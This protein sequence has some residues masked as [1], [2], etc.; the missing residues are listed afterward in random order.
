MNGPR[1]TAVFL[2]VTGVLFAALLVA[3]GWRAGV[4]GADWMAPAALV[5]GVAVVVVAVIFSRGVGEGRL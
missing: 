2:L 3:L 5:V 1:A 4:S